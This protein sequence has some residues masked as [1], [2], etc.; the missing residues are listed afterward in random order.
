MDLFI[1]QINYQQCFHVKKNY[2][3]KQFFKK[4]NKFRKYKSNNK[5][6]KEFLLS[7]NLFLNNLVLL[8]IKFEVKMV[9]YQNKMHSKFLKKNKI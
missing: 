6:Y 7:L 4:L 8:L 2:Q 3:K 9:N 5:I 1:M